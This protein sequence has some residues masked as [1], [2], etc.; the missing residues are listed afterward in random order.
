MRTMVLFDCPIRMEVG[1]S[2]A[3]AEMV[4]RSTSNHFRIGLILAVIVP[5][6]DLTDLVLPPP[7]KG[8][9]FAARASVR[10]HQFLALDDVSKGLR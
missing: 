5:K 2:L 3:K 4:V 9:D 10:R 1:L 6:T 7:L 8:F